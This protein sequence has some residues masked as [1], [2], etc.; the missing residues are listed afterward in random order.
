MT[1]VLSTVGTAVAKKTSK[2]VSH[3]LPA[4]TASGVEVYPDSKS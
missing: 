4:L 1:I 3:N 2:Y